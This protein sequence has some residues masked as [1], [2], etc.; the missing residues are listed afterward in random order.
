MNIVTLFVLLALAAT[1]VSLT[2]GIVAMAR[3]GE[4][5]H[6]SSVQWMGWRVLFQAIAL[7]LVL[8]PHSYFH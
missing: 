8:M 1:V 2:S 4:V 7:I 3:D 6:Q 5:G